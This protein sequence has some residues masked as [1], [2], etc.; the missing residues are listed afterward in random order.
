MQPIKH[1]GSFPEGRWLRN[2]SDSSPYTFPDTVLCDPFPVL[3]SPS[4]HPYTTISRT[5]E[6]CY[7]AGKECLSRMRF[8]SISISNGKEKG[9]KKM[10]KLSCLITE[11]NLVT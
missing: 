4:S 8:A 9:E 2:I 5:G 7:Q 6:W 3:S 11:I 10:S 1:F